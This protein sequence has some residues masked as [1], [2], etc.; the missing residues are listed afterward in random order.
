MWN[1]EKIMTVNF[2][3]LGVSDDEIARAM[4]FGIRYTK[5]QRNELKR[6]LNVTPPSE[7]DLSSFE[8]KNKFALSESYRNFLKENNGGI[9]DKSIF[10][11]NDTEYVLDRLLM[12]GG[13]SNAYD[14]I[15]NHIDVFSSRIPNS[16]IPIGRSPGGDLFLLKTSGSDCGSVWYW[17]HEFES[18]SNGSA[19]WENTEKLSSDFGDFLRNLHD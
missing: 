12:F 17:H 4:S 9:P 13:N 6:A 16:T 15:E 3:K 18:P 11:K 8:K 14:S 7:N 10:K 5:S 2:K 1:K 19:P